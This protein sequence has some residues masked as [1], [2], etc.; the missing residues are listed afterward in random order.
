MCGVLEPPSARDWVGLTGEPL[1]IDEVNAWA[2]TPGSGAVVCFLGVVR[3][4]AEGRDGV[5]GLSYEA[6]EDVAI[7]RLEE[8]AAETRHRWPEVERLALLHRVGDLALSEASVVV[9]A[10]SPHRAEAFEAARFAIDTLKETVPIWKRETWEG[11]SD[12]ALCSHPVHEV[13]EVVKP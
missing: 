13:E 12:W 9:V 7:R 3:D 5:T 2:T 8:V 11:G 6:Y 10:S 1:P 4:H